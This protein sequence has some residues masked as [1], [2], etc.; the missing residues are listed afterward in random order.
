MLGHGPSRRL[1]NRV[2]GADV[3]PYLA[4]A[5]MIGSGLFGIEHGL[6]PGPFAAEC[7]R[8]MP[9]ARPLPRNLPAALARFVGSDVAAEILTP[10]V[11]R[12]LTCFAELEIDS[13]FSVVTDW[14]RETYFE[15][16]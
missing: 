4:Y 9:E 13:Y 11:V 3:N 2:P 6:E 1:E 16:A 5:A 7:A 10:E 8:T 14:E 15:Q 12:H